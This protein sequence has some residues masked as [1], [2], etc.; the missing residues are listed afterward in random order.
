M[1]RVLPTAATDQAAV[2]R[3]FQKD[4]FSGIEDELDE[5]P[6]VKKSKTNAS[7]SKSTKV[8]IALP[9]PKREKVLA[10][11]AN[12]QVQAQKQEAQAAKASFEIVPME[13]EVSDDENAIAETLAIGAEF[14]NKKRK[15]DIID[16]SYNSVLILL[17]DI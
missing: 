2:S 15:S 11:R 12:P 16:S 3:W 17:G 13:A 4:V 9:N 5:I 7:H 8:E 14:L 1:R 10:K 6:I